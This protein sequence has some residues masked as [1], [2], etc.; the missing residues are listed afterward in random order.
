MD[1]AIV[2]LWCNEK[3]ISSR[4]VARLTYHQCQQCDYLFLDPRFR[5]SAAAEKARYELHKNNVRD[6]GYQLF[7]T[8]L[9]NQITQNF[10][11]DSLGLDYGAGVDSAISFLLANENYNVKKYDPFFNVDESVLSL[12]TYD[13]VILC[14]VAEHLFAPADVFRNI[15]SYLKPNGVIFVMTS[16]LTPAIDFSTW[17]YRRD[18]THVGFFTAKTFAQKYK[19]EIKSGNLVILRNK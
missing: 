3:E 12:G 2:C 14:E 11:S 19:A 4:V 18:T 5:I 8:P 7:V 13:Y 9:K 10:S 17:A 15:S 1:Q 6:P 16:L